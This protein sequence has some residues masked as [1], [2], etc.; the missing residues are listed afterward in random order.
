MAEV[1]EM[2]QFCSKL[3]NVA[4]FDDYCPNGLQVD[5]GR[6]EVRRLVTGVTACQELIDRAV[7]WDAD[8][9]LV[10][11]GFF[12]RGESLPL[13][14]YKGRRVRTLMQ[15]G[16]SLMAY[17]LPLDA[18]P[19][20][21]NNRQLALLLGLNDANSIA[22]TGGLLWSGALSAPL[23]PQQLRHR[24]ADLLGREPLHIAVDE[25]PVERL[26]WCTGAAQNYIETA[27]Q[28]GVDAYISGE[29]SEQTVHLARELGIHYFAAGHH[30]T[31][32]YG[33]R[34]LGEHLADR[35][36]L[37]HRFIEVENPV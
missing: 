26:C 17:H 36:G 37:E 28:Q 12:W 24:I 8:L 19:E 9:L 29:I 21:G 11:H 25:G 14:G 6:G 3:M 35:F 16:L 7:A 34:A 1:Y 13:T 2:E 18:H 15:R 23:P 4:A 33:I 22:E 20:L 30:A 31:E 32:R 5:A 27:A 10:H